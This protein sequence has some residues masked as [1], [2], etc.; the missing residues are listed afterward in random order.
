MRIRHGHRHTQF[1]APEGNIWNSTV[2]FDRPG[3]YVLRGIASDG[4]LFTYQNVNVT[5]SP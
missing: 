1:R 5:V 4:S 3:E 2:V